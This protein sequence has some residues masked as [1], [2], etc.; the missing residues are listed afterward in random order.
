[1]KLIKQLFTIAL[2]LSVIVSCNQKNT[3]KPDP[4]SSGNELLKTGPYCGDS[5]YDLLD[6][7]GNLLATLNVFSSPNNVF[8]YVRN[9]TGGDGAVS[10][11]T[12]S[13]NGAAFSTHA[14]H[15][16][17]NYINQND[18][19]LSCGNTYAISATAVIGGVTAS[20]NIGE[21]YFLECC[22]WGEETAWAAG[23]RYNTRG[24]WATYVTYTGTAKTV[25]LLAGKNTKIGTVSFSA[26]SGG[27]VTIT[28][29]LFTRYSFAD[30]DENIKI[31]DYKFAPSGNPAP[32]QFDWKFTG[33]YGE[34]EPFSVVVDQ[35]NF[36]GVHVDALLSEICEEE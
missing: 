5:Y 4:V 11:L 21:E 18:N 27:S 17:W 7:S 19:G 6:A 10:S 3:V 26:P 34:T 22:C 35:N 1:M 14:F 2:L 9:A 29:D 30:V 12:G 36:Y 8:I 13:I 25:D 31:Q 16:Y 24:N 15:P 28:I 23:T 20:I 32:G 33:P